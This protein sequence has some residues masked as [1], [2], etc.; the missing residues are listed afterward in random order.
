MSTGL[1]L[2]LVFMALS[3]IDSVARTRRGKQQQAKL[4]PEGE[5]EEW[6]AEPS[7]ARDAEREREAEESGRK[8]P[9]D[10]LEELAGLEKLMGPGYLQKLMGPAFAGISEEKDEEIP[11][12]GA[13]ALPARTPEAA[14]DSSPERGEKRRAAREGLS[15]DQERRRAEART[16]SR[17]DRRQVVGR[18][19]P[20]RGDPPAA[21]DRRLRESTGWRSR[22][23]RGSEAEDRKLPERPEP[24]DRPERE[25]ARL[26]PASATPSFGKSGPRR[27]RLYRELFGGGGRDSLRRAFVLKEVL[28]AP[29]SERRED[30]SG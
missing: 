24:A 12:G 9:R 21:P 1:L 18:R 14:P 7:S 2:F 11:E 8:E 28:D 20:S 23:S 25:A 30:R 22:F 6:R 16:R 27:T 13:S 19:R 10:G 5:D 3:I 17:D 15:R 29:A 4:P 26:A